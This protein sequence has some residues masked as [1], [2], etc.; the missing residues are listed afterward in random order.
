MTLERVPVERGTDELIEAAHVRRE[1]TADVEQRLARVTGEAVDPDQTVAARVGV[2]GDLRELW[3]RE[4]ATRWGPQRLGEL[5]VWAA[6]AATTDAVQ[7]GYDA[8]APVL[9]DNLTTAMESITHPAPAR[10]GAD[11][12]GYL[13]QEEFQARRDARHGVVAPQAPQRPAAE[14]EPDD[15]LFAFDPSTLRS[16][17]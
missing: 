15:D 7:R 8:L 16:D 14:P 6:Q 17:R 9:G 13:S 1:A 12:A 3:L 4:D 2:H 11:P 10:G 5:I